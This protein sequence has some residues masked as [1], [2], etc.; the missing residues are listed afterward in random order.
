MQCND[1]QS[2]LV[3][4]PALIE[5]EIQLPLKSAQSDSSTSQNVDIT[6]D[7]NSRNFL[8]NRQKKRRPPRKNQAKNPK[9]K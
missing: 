7:I 1:K 4:E 8:S 2:L 3:T 9:L 5:S 6:S